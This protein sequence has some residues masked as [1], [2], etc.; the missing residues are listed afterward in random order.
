[1]GSP[2][3]WSCDRALSLVRLSLGRWGGLDKTYVVLLEKQ[4]RQQSW[5]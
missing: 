4:R 2:E 1:M 3:L 5:G